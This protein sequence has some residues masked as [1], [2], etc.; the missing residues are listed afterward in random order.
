MCAVRKEEV[1]QNY[2]AVQAVKASII[3]AKTARY[4]IGP[5]INGRA[6]IYP[7]SRAIK[8]TEKAP[9]LYLELLVEVFGNFSI[10]FSLVLV[11]LVYITFYPLSPFYRFI[12]V[13]RQISGETLR[14]NETNGVQF[15]DMR[16]ENPE[17]AQWREICQNETDL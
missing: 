10:Y 14:N 12:R 17:F 8:L 1:R 3:G 15:S 13:R 9:F 6:K 7:I 2:V 5:Q 4:Q 16:V 11:T